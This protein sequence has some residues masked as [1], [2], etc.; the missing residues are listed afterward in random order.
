MCCSLYDD[1]M[2][3]QMEWHV[4]S[5]LNWTIGHPTVDNFLKMATKDSVYD[6]ETESLALYILEIAL[7]HREFVSRHSSSLALSALALS[8]SILGRPQAR[9]SE[10]AHQYDGSIFRELSQKLGEPS[11][12]LSRKYGS[13][14]YC[15]VARILAQYLAQQAMMA[16][17]APPTPVYEM[18]PPTFS[19]ANNTGYFSTFATPQK[20]QFASVT[21]HGLYTPP[22]TPEE[23]HAFNLPPTP[24]PQGQQHFDFTGVPQY[25]NSQWNFGAY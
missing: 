4:L 3:L 15:G 12:I 11:N 22:I 8:R 14:R 10:W 9:P 18:T 1:D 24:T 20:S 23:K 21:A 2:F 5:T 7:Y 6:P 25:H 17:R 19:K 16:A 13:A